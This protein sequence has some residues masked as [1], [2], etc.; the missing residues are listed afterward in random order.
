MERLDR[1]YQ[2]IM[3]LS[4]SMIQPKSFAPKVSFA[5]ENNGIDLDA[6]VSWELTATLT[7]MGGPMDPVVF[8]ESWKGIGSTVEEA[9]VDLAK[10]LDSWAENYRKNLQQKA[11]VVDRALFALSSTANLK[12]LWAKPED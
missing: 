2:A 12:D 8:Q 3:L 6:S 11:S 7:G 1:L 4:G 10:S 9:Y 5:L